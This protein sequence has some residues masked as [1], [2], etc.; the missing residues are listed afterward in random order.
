VTKL[1]PR[2]RIK[3]KPAKQPA[4]IERVVAMGCAVCGRPAVYHHINERGHGRETRDDAFGCGLCPEHHNMG[5]ASIHALG[6]NIL[7]ENAHGVDLVDVAE[8]NNLESRY[9]GILI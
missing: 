1:L 6:S 9:M 2:V 8:M 7:F 5:N 4:H 3:I